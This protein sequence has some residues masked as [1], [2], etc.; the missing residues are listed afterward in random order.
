MHH[1]SAPPAGTGQERVQAAATGLLSRIAAL[2]RALFRAGEFGLTR[3]EASVLDALEHEPLRVTALA[4]RTGT[5][6]PRVTVVLHQ[7]EERN[8]VTRVRCAEDRRAV[9]SS[10]TPDG[11]RLLAQARQ[12]MAAALLEALQGRVE[13]SERA[14]G[15]ARDALAVLADAMDQEVS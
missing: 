14:V 3:S 4:A 5:A 6:Q 11:R 9:E 7:L 15:A 1:P 13:D 8:L 12:R 10:L 2:S